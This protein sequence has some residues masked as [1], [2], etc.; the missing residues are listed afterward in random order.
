MAAAAYAHGNG[1]PLS[2]AP[3]TPPEPER[4]RTVAGG[5]VRALRRARELARREG[6]GVPAVASPFPSSHVI[7]PPLDPHKTECPASHQLLW[8][9]VRE[10]AVEE[11]VRSQAK[12]TASLSHAPL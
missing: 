1:V 9:A 2:H 6:G 5:V 3:Q 8:E 4:S 12:P 7:A 11:A 10:E